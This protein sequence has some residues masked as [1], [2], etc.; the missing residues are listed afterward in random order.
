MEALLRLYSIIDDSCLSY[1]L[2][3]CKSFFFLPFESYTVKSL[4]CFSMGSFRFSLISENFLNIKEFNPLLHM[5]KLCFIKLLV[6][7]FLCIC[8]FYIPPHLKISLKFYLSVQLFLYFTFYICWFINL[9]T[10]LY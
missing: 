8:I 4:T 10:N 5:C 7:T 3:V 6:T 9:S 2:W 1:P